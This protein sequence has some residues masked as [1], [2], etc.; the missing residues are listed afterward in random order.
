MLDSTTFS[1][2]AEPSQIFTNQKDDMK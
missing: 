1:K 2:N